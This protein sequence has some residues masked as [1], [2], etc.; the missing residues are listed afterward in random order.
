MTGSPL[1][2]VPLKKPT[3]VTENEMIKV[4]LTELDGNGNPVENGV[5]VKEGTVSLEFV[6]D[7]NIKGQFKGTKAG[8]QLVIDVKE[9][10][11]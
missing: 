6:K 11:C 5:Q 1:V 7:D 8:D 10:L 3:E 9:S 2:S 4:D